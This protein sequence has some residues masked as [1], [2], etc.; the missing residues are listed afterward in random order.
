[1]DLQPN[2]RRGPEGGPPELPRAKVVA[3]AGVRRAYRDRAAAR[4]S[5]A[6]GRT[7]S[8]EVSVEISSWTGGNGA[9]PR[10]P[11]RRPD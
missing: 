10:L 7:R 5:P 2:A 11:A 3:V 6:P 4:R 1:V 9:R 8:Y